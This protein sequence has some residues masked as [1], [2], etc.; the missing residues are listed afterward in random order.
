LDKY[1]VLLFIFIF[2]PCSYR[3]QVPEFKTDTVWQVENYLTR[4]GFVVGIWPHEARL[5]DTGEI[6]RLKEVFGFSHIYFYNHHREEKFKMI[7]E[8]GFLPHQIMVNIMPDNYKERI[9]TFNGAYAYYI[10]E[11]NEH[12]LLIDGMKEA[13][14]KNSPGS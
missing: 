8:G 12:D 7:L 11:P 3:A 2:Y 14:I 5:A 1:L 10:D 4:E 9:K 13:I 6:K